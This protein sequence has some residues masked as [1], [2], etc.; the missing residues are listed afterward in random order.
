MDGVNFVEKQSNESNKRIFLELVLSFEFWRFSR[1]FR[2]DPI[3]YA[4]PKNL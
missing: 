2:I 4:K 3:T 1:A